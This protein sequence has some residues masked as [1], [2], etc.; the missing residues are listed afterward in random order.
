MDL[1]IGHT[2]GEVL[3][4]LTNKVGRFLMKKYFE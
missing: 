4:G 2:K 3:I 1:L